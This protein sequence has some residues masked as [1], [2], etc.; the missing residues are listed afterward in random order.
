M[1]CTRRVLPIPASPS[2]AST[3]ARPSLSSRTEAAARA[4]S[5]SRPTSPSTEDTPK[6]FATPRASHASTGVQRV[7]RQERPAGAAWSRRTGGDDLAADRCRWQAS[8]TPGPDMRDSQEDAQLRLAVRGGSGRSRAALPRDARRRPRVEPHL[9]R[10]REDARG[11]LDLRHLPFGGG[12]PAVLRARRAG[13]RPLREVRARPREIRGPPGDPRLRRWPAGRRTHGLS[14][15]AGAA[16]R[17]G[18]EPVGSRNRIVTLLR[19]SR[20]RG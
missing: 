16:S 20:T 1:L 9:P 19:E 10:S 2:I 14:F 3:D 7:A 6:L 5:A 13:R 17:R 12:L 11:A 18:R 15:A 4:S 8:R